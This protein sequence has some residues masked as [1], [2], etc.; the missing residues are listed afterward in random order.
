M[1]FGIMDMQIGALIPSEL[2]AE[3]ARGYITGFDHVALVQELYTQGFNP[4]ELGGDL[5]L[6]FPQAFNPP[7]IE[8][9][10]DLKE[11]E[12][13]AYT[14]HLPLWSVEPSTPLVPVRHGSVH[15]VTDIIQAT[16][17][18]DP[19]MYVLHATGALAAE[20]YRMPL[21]D[22]G[23]AFLL[24]QFQQ[25]AYQSLE[26]ILSET[27]IPSRKLAIETIEFPL[28]LT[29][30]LAEHLDLSICF[31]TGHVL[32]GFSGPLDFFEALELCLPRLGEVHLHDGPSQGPEHTIGYGKDHA[33]LGTGDLD[34][35]RL[36]NRLR[37]VD[38][39]GPVIFELTVE[40]ALES[41]NVALAAINQGH[42]S[43]TSPNV[44]AVTQGHRSE[45]SPNVGAVTQGHRSETS[46]NV[47]AATQEHRSET[48]PNVGDDGDV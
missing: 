39:T 21:P 31:D 41:L 3:T 48:S 18:L 6:F 29:L 17:P 33:P 28:D 44:G 25:N 15:A 32:V 23:K 46:P 37:D 4:I 24:R 30:E 38:F 1:R 14:V 5:T 35:G 47:G 7:T 34:V 36:L 20:F 8:R 13:L 45:T 26:T 43:E 12:G 42:R 9:L 19:E 11:V 16:L 2:S 10:G 27:G 22:S 40:E